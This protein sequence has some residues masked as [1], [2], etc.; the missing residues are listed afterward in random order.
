MAGPDTRT[1]RNLA[2]QG[3]AIPDPDGSGGRFPIRDEADARKAIRAVGRAS[4][5]E[6][7]RRKVRRFIV[8]RLRALGLTDLIPSSWAPDGSLKS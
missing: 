5:G 1:R 4:G 6:E 2:K 7:G 3:K 8:K